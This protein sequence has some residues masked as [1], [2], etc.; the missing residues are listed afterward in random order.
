MLLVAD[1][2]GAAGALR[3]IAARGETLLVLGDLINFIDYRTNEGIV[4]EVAGTEFVA[5]LVRLRAAGNLDEARRRWGEFSN[6]REAE[7]RLRFDA[8]IEAAYQDVCAAL[9]GVVGYVIHGNVDHPAMLR[10]HLPEGVRFMDAEA[11]DIDGHRIGFAGGGMPALGIPGE[12]DEEQM[13]AKL[14]ALGTVDVLCTHVPPAYPALSTDVVG[15]RQK[16]SIAVRE[17]LERVQPAFHYF[18]DIHQPQ[19]TRWTAGKTTCINVGYFR[20]TGRA[21]RHG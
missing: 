20:A 17:Y 1:V 6:G 9:E 4:S 15:G 10:K 21:V 3:K 11:I 16:G 2:H 13:A 8:L 12:V 19:A 18:G 14:V 7:L 5:E